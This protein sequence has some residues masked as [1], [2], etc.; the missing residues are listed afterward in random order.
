[1]RLLFVAPDMH[2]GG[3][4]RHWATVIPALARRG[5]GVRLLCLNDE[6][7][8]FHELRAAGV[9]SECLHLGG[10]ADARG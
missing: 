2:R 4:E 9:P 3:A 7:P 1:M 8:L 10:R 6:G 5:A